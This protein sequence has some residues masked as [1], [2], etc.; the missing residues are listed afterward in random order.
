[1]LILAAAL[2]LAGPPSVSADDTTAPVA[3]TST[4]A[5]PAD[6]D[7]DGTVTGKERRQARRAAR[8]ARR[9]ARAAAGGKEMTDAEA[10]AADAQA[11]SEKGAAAS[12][13]AAGAAAAMRNSMP[14]P[15]AGGGVPGG[16]GAGGQQPAG[17]GTGSGGGTS[18]GGAQVGTGKSDGAGAF[19]GGGAA[20]SEFTSGASGDP[21][22]PKAPSD[23]ALAARSG[24]APAFAKAGLKMSAD[25]RS[26]LRLD[27]TPATAADY[28]RL[29]QEIGS[30][31]AALGRRP[32]F[33]SA[34]SPEHY[35]DLK[36][37]YKDKKDD[38]VFKDVGTTAGD[39]DFVHTASCD[40]LSGDCNKSVE[41]GTYKKGDYV[42]PEDLDNMW[43]NLQKELDASADQSQTGGLPNPGAARSDLAREK[44]LESARILTEG[45]TG[46]SEKTDAGGASTTGPVVTPVSQAV[47]SARKLW[48][49]AAALAF[50][51]HG[52]APGSANGSLLLVIG[53]SA[54]AV[55]GAGILFLRRKG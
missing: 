31:P 28:A 5:D 2:L 1:M 17:A 3:E 4:E 9:R 52:E 53:A 30:M 44:A 22:R 25:G 16:G 6:T 32:D 39:R 37:G 21:G 7:G 41:K 49:S 20:R 11:A 24:Y 40:K 47:D 36:R 45:I 27:G 38:P 19:A 50:P 35:S 48:T 42:A 51:G 43:S 10:D 12:S 33:F 18:P 29:Q 26:V 8:C 14:S 23:F 34:V 55:L 46:K 13:K 15:D 54:F